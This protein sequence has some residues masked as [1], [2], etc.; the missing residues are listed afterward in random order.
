MKKK[1]MLFLFMMLVPILGVKAD[2]IKKID[3]RINI[4]EDGSAEIKEIWNVKASSGS[5][6]YKQMY[7]LGGMELSNYKVLMDG[8]ELTYKT[9]NVNENLSQKAGYYGINYVS[10]GIE[11]C[12]GK[13]DMKEHTFT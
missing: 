10:E 9:W 4:L 3:M 1:I 5:E 13:S 2:T 7:N 8:K 6:W 11:L 12:F